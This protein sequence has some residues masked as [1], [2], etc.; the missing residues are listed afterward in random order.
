MVVSEVLY[1]NE[2]V[3]SVLSNDATGRQ[4]R[5]SSMRRA[6]RV[7]SENRLSVGPG[8]QRLSVAEGAQRLGISASQHEQLLAEHR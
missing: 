5:K 3:S 7:G 6:S 1:E 2:D 4:R 8:G